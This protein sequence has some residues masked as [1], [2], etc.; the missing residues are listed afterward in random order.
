MAESSAK[1]AHEVTITHRGY[2]VDCR[3]G[4]HS[5]AKS[6][7][8]AEAKALEHAEAIADAS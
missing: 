4:W 2:D 1:L 6:F 3:C 8:E 7:T 5:D